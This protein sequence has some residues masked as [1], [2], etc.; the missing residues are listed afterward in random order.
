MILKR[1]TS[2]R[3]LV[4]YKDIEFC[5]S[6]DQTSKKVLAEFQTKAHCISMVVLRLRKTKSICRLLLSLTLLFLSYYFLIGRYQYPELSIELASFI[7]KTFINNNLDLQKVALAAKAPIPSSFKPLN[8]TV[9]PLCLVTTWERGR[10]PDY[11]QLML[12][13]VARNQEFAKLFLFHSHAEN[14]P[15]PSLY[16]NVQMIDLQ[17]INKSYEYGGF[18]KFLAHRLCDIFKN[19]KRQRSPLIAVVVSVFSRLSAVLI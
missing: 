12:A 15:N 7:Q 4:C 14:L 8:A 11:A 10:F 19:E 1:E 13:S 3:D 17:D 18:A 16:P 6:Q 9:I 5:L 2:Y